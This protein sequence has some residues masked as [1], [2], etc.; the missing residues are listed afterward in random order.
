MSICFFSKEEKNILETEFEDIAEAAP[1]LITGGP[2]EFTSRLAVI[3]S[4]K[5]K[6]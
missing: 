5:K 1:Y 3:Q 4:K 2:A 6:G